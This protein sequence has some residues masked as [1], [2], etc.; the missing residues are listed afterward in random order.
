MPPTS[1][2]AFEMQ[3]MPAKLT[4]TFRVSLI[5]PLSD[6]NAFAIFELC[7]SPRKTSST[8]PS[9]ASL[10]KTDLLATL[11]SKERALTKKSTS[12]QAEKSPPP[13]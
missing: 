3:Y 9:S 1:K 13:H 6:C 12:E 2:D 11:F 4:V 7:Y 8:S 5:L 10:S